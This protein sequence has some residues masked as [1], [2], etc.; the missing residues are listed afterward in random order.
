MLYNL[1]MACC[2]LPLDQKVASSPTHGNFTIHCLNQPSKSLK[3]FGMDADPID[4]CPARFGYVL[5]TGADSV[6]A[7]HCETKIYPLDDNLKKIIQ[8]VNNIMNDQP[9]FQHPDY[10]EHN[11]AD[12]KVY[13]GSKLNKYEYDLKG[14]QNN[15]LGD[16]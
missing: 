9:G 14:Q 12:I 5:G 4:G 15:S 6:K 7:N 13:E 3:N 10:K 16:H 1:F 8:L 11:I 2:P